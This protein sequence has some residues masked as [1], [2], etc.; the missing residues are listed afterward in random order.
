M[1][2]RMPQR[3]SR[4]NKGRRQCGLYV[5]VPYC[6]TKC[7]YCDFY[8]VALDESGVDGLIQ[9]VG[10]E[11]RSRI[12]IVD[13]EIRTVFCG[14]GTPTVLP[15][16]LLARLA[17]ELSQIGRTHGVEEF[18]VEANPGT[19]DDEK[20]GLLLR[21]GVNRVSMGA[22]TFDVE[23]LAVLE[24]LH[25]PDD[26]RTSVA[27]VRLRG[28]RQISIDLIFGIPGQTLGSWNESLQRAM[29][30]EPDHVAC[31]GLTYEPGTR[32]YGQHKA[33]VVTACDEEL[34]AEM[35]LHA[36]DTLA[37][38][39]YE[40]YEI[41]NFARPG[42]QCL[43]NLAY[44]HNEPYIGVGPSAAGYLNGRR[45]KNVSD[46]Q[47][48]VQMMETQ[49]HAEVESEVIDKRTLMT[50][51]LMMQLRLV[52]GL[53]IADFRERTGVDPVALFGDA[54]DQLVERGLVTVSGTHI[55]LT[56]NGRLVADRVIVELAS[57][58]A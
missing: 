35:Y 57:S 21:A 46:I 53:S 25:S 30:L 17:D 56:R 12:R 27:R 42:C 15:P 45:Y 49:G 7:G 44:W 37:V 1:M 3:N 4:S 54:L 52:E 13:Q 2:D 16:D 18:T 22:Q 58:C 32:L 41:S 47:A 23:E 40:Q 50:E 31:Y 6:H 9:M 20:L 14:G 10:R 8:S 5:H 36:I 28:I 39:G 19:I 34:E 11:V 51:M 24:R 48:Y 38:A 33:G 29:E 26:V 55:A 43:H